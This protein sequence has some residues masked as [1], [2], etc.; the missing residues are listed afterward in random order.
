MSLRS[1]P[2]VSHFSIF[3]SH[4]VFTCDHCLC[5]VLPA[6][7]RLDVLI[8]ICYFFPFVRFLLNLNCDNTLP[9]SVKR[10]TGLLLNGLSVHCR[11]ACY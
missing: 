7:Q 11:I 2:A 9:L 10:I 5:F 1:E 3:C 6:M 8:P 4:R